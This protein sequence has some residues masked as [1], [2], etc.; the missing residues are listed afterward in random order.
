MDLIC[1][2]AGIEKQAEYISVKIQ[3]SN[4]E[5]FTDNLQI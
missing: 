4:N 1:A 2:C 5:P 3:K